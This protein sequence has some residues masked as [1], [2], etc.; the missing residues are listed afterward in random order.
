M[1]N[2]RFLDRLGFA[3]EGFGHAWRGESSFRV[4]LTVAVLVQF[5]FLSTHNALYWWGLATLVSAAVITAELFNTALEHALDAVHPDLH[6]SIKIAKDC[7]S[8]AVLCLCVAALG[9]SVLF[10]FDY[11]FSA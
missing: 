9:L 2:R 6:P 5:F 4:H 7:A 8:A 3:W 11:Y 10:V 1:K